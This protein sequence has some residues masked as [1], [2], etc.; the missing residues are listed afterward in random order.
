MQTFYSTEVNNLAELR[1][2]GCKKY[3]RIDI[4]HHGIEAEKAN[5]HKVTGIAICQCGVGTGFEIE[6]DTTVYVSG[7]NSY[8]FVS[9]TFS[10]TVK[11]LY[12]E[13]ELSFQSG[14]PD[15]SV[16]MCRAS[17]E[18]ALADK[19]FSGRDLYERIM[20][21]KVVLG[22][23]EV[24]LAH[25][26]RL[27]TREAIHR[28]ELVPLSDIPSMLSATVRVLNKLANATNVQPPP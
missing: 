4:P 1:C 8:G 21:A 14:A 2:A 7:K 25:A 24:G 15:A 22:D 12:A 10:E 27:I 20:N 5:P 11:T 17:V 26:S 16:A 13:A 18:T 9:G 6:S 23:V 3:M 19:G 28:G